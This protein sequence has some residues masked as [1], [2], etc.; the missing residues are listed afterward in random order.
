MNKGL[1]ITFEGADG[2]GKTTQLMLIAKYLKEHGTDVLVTREPGAKGL[3]EKLREILLNYEGEVS[4]QAEAFLFL[5]DRA[6][7]MD[8]I[9]KPSVAAGKVVL[10]DRHTDSTVA[11]QGYGRGIDISRINMLNDIATGGRKPD[12]T[13]VFDVDVETSLARVGK[14]KDRMENAGMEFFNRVRNGYLQIAKQEPERV[15]VIDATQSIE[16]IHIQ[17]IKLINLSR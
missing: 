12:L 11:Y 7:H 8:V 3:G 6:Q 10:C 9:I 5:A 2:C 16:A 14:E 1:F 17:V 4:S 15:K 13:I